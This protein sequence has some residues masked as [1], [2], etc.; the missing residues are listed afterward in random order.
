MSWERLVYVYTVDLLYVLV[1]LHLHIFFSSADIPLTWMVS[2][3]FTALN[4][5]FL[6]QHGQ[7]FTNVETSLRMPFH[8][9]FNFSNFATT[10]C[11]LSDSS[12][13]VLPYT[14]MSSRYDSH[15]LYRRKWNIV[16]VDDI[17]ILFGAWYIICVTCVVSTSAVYLWLFMIFVSQ[18]AHVGMCSTGMTG[19]DVMLNNHC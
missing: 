13:F 4:V 7:R 6:W 12:C 2:C 16:I 15:I 10:D 14:S 3:V 8:V 19:I 1:R 17:V 9:I 11:R 5:S 18:F